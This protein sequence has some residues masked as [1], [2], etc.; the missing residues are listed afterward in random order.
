MTR[1]LSG[2]LAALAL[3]AS[4]LTLSAAASPAASGAEST[5]SY[6]A[7]SAQRQV[8]RSGCRTYAFKYRITAPGNDWMAEISLISPS[9]VSLSSHTFKKSAGDA[10]K[11][12]RRFRLCDAST[13]P[14]RHTITMKVTSYDTRTED[15][16]RSTPTRFR[17]TNR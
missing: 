11:D 10:R 2:V 7:T 4:M 13:E 9:G 12:T 15:T 6:G 8:L 17:L 16:R 1:I 3:V 14:G 5:A